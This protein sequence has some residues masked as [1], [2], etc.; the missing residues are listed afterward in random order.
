MTRIGLDLDVLTPVRGVIEYE[1]KDSRVAFTRFKDVYSKKR[2]SK[3]YLPNNSEQSYVDFDGNLNLHVRM[4]QYNIIF[5]L[6]ELF[7]VTVQG[8]LQKPTYS[9][10]KQQRPQHNRKTTA[11]R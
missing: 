11:A 5:K 1:I 2:V 4:K 3:F 7:T 9:L 8:D 6:A 10:H